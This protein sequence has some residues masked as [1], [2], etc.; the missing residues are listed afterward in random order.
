[1]TDSWLSAAGEQPP[2]RVRVASEVVAS[3]AALAAQDVVGIA[4]MREPTS[5]NVSLPLHRQHGHRGVQLQMVGDTGIRLDLY[6]AITP[7]ASVAQVAEELQRK[8][9][10]AIHSML[11]LDAVEI[12]LHIAEIEGD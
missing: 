10:H 5:L 11:G 9:A 8:V 4:A 2:G 7:Q 3:I 12:N 6:V 1:M